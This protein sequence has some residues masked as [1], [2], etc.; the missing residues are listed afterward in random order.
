M[1]LKSNIISNLNNKKENKELYEQILQH[2]NN[3]LKVSNLKIVAKSKKRKSKLC[4]KD[5]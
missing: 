5:L 1:E 3:E 4:C 2:T